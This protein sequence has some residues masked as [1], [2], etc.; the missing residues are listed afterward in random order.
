MVF[1]INLLPEKYRKKGFSIQFDARV[2]GGIGGIVLVVLL[3]LTT[4]KVNRQADDLTEQ[5]DALLGQKEEVETIAQRVR[6][7]QRET[8]TIEERIATLE[9]LGGRNAVQLRI[10]EIINEQLPPNI[11]LQEVNQVPPRQQA[12]ARGSGISED[13]VLNFEGIALR[14]E[15]VTEWI[16][17]LQEQDLIQRVQTNY[18]RP[19][20]VQDA[21]IFEFSLTAVMN[22]SG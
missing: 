7:Q 2:L 9:G 14:K 21:D 3:V 4:I 18:L 19:T 6:N 17:R 1:E 12:G 5:R 20:R 10:L 15:G 11:W 16:T 13:Q 22:I 8:Q